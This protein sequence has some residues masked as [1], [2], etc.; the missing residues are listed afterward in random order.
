M[1][2]MSRDGRSLTSIHSSVDDYVS[3]PA[4][5]PDRRWIAVL[6]GDLP[7]YAGLSLV[8]SDGNRWRHLKRDENS[9]PARSWRR[10]I[11]SPDGRYIAFFHFESLV[12]IDVRTKRER[13]LRI[14]E[15]IYETSVEIVGRGR[16]GLVLLRSG[17]LV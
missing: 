14:L 7:D 17:D 9:G 6:A 15:D 2:V 12:L 1:L 4:W 3:G 5:S 13:A 11:W 16:Q 8:S 10:L